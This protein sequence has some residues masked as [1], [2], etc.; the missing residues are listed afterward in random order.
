MINLYLYNLSS[1]PAHFLSQSLPLGGKSQS[2]FTVSTRLK[3]PT[4]VLGALPWFQK[5]WL[6]AETVKWTP[7]NNPR[8]QGFSNSFTVNQFEIWTDTSD[9]LKSCSTLQSRLVGSSVVFDFF[10]FPSLFPG[11]RFHGSGMRVLFS[12]SWCPPKSK[13]SMALN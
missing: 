9:R 3:S 10:S 1:S 11:L 4:K 8:I 7:A 2:L 5:P 6:H 12:I 13:R